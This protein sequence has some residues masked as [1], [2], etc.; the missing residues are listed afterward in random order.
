MV[1]PSGSSAV[2]PA[3]AL[4][5][6]GISRL[7]SIAFTLPGA[8]R[9]AVTVGAVVPWVPCCPGPEPPEGAFVIQPAITETPTIMITTIVIQPI[10]DTVLSSII[11][12]LTRGII[13]ESG[14][15]QYINA[16][17]NHQDLEQSRGAACSLFIRDFSRAKFCIRRTAH[18]KSERCYG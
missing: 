1:I 7:K 2:H 13:L 14:V 9:V 18:Y 6:K 10:R 11:S 16:E 4:G 5:R 12:H 3:G 17:I 15:K 8:G